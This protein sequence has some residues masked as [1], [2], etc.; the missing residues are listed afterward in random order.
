MMLFYF[1]MVNLWSISCRQR[2]AAKLKDKEKP[3]KFPSTFSQNNAEE[4]QVNMS[5]ML[6][7]TF[8][9]RQTD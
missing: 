4:D 6:V 9:L 1:S 8:I 3:R 2:E 5:Y 7:A